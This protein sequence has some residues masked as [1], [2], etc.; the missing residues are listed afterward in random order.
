MC[1]PNV[2]Y[3]QP[4]HTRHRPGHCQVDATCAVPMHADM[5]VVNK[6]TVQLTRRELCELQKSWMEA[7]AT[8]GLCM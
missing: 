8:Y 4:C 5:S 2:G 3:H 1:G 7:N 6:L